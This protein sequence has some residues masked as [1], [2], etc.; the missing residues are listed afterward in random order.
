MAVSGLR[1][2]DPFTLYCGRH[3]SWALRRV[4]LVLLLIRQ[5][6]CVSTDYA[7]SSHHVSRVVFETRPHE[8]EDARAAQLSTL[9]SS[10]IGNTFKYLQYRA[11]LSAST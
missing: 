8:D 4:C 9:R 7:I 11:A 3:V 5:Q 1:Q 10:G 6:F 2:K